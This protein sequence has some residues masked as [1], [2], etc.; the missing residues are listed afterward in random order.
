MQGCDS[1]LAYDLVDDPAM[2]RIC[3]PSPVGSS[4]RYRSR[5]GYGG[6]YVYCGTRGVKLVLEHTEATSAAI[7]VYESRDAGT[8]SR[9]SIY[10]FI[11]HSGLL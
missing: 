8:T 11:H 1:L 10:D 5:E 6:I 2:H 9:C 3:V 7:M 4:E